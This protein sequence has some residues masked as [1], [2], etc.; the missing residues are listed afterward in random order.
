MINVQPTEESDDD[1]ESEQKIDVTVSPM[2]SK[3]SVKSNHREELKAES[4]TTT[5]GRK[6]SKASTVLSATNSAKEE[7]ATSPR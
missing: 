6:P 1:E 5:R 4:V 3:S 7:K 2:A